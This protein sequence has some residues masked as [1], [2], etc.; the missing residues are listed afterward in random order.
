MTKRN[1]SARRKPTAPAAISPGPSSELL[2]PPSPIFPRTAS[3]APLPSQHKGRQR[4]VK[5]RYQ[6][7]RSSSYTHQKRQPS[8][9]SL[10]CT[11][12]TTTMAQRKER[13]KAQTTARRK[14]KMRDL[15]RSDGASTLAGDK[16][17]LVTQRGGFLLLTVPSPHTH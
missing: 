6:T 12:T 15:T 17:T 14:K 1:Q 2:Q 9:A 4:G 11:T 10:P 5:A 16:F 3:K 13:A 8:P 7:K